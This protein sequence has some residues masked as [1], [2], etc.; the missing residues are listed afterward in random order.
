MSERKKEYQVLA[1][2]YRP[3][4]LEGLIGQ[5]V[6]VQTLTNAIE[7]DRIPHAF[8]M[9]GIRGVGKTSTARIIARSLV[10][11]GKDGKN[12]KPTTKPCGV[13]NQCMAIANDSHVDILEM[14][15][16]SRTGVND[17]REII[18]NVHYAPVMARYKIYII[19]EVHMLS[20]SAFNALLK[21]L[22]EPPEHTKFIFATTEI[23]KIP[24]TVL[25][26]CMRFDLARVPV[27]LLNEHLSA[28]AK[29]EKVK[30]KDDALTLISNSA[31]GSVRDA[32]SLLDQAIGISNKGDAIDVGLVSSMLGVADSAAMYDLF[33]DIVEG[34]PK[35][36]IEQ[37]RAM[38][39][40]GADP[41]TILQDLLEMSHFIT[42]LK[43]IPEMASA[44]HL[45]ETDVKRGKDMAAKLSIPYLSRM[46][47]MLLKGVQEAQYAPNSLVAAEMIL[48]RL[49]YVSDAPTPG[50]LIKKIQSEGVASTASS[51]TQ[52]T[53]SS[54][55]NTVQASADG[56]IRNP[57]NFSEMVELFKVKGEKLKCSYLRNISVIDFDA[58]HHKV[59]FSSA[60]GVPT[61]F[62]GEVGEMLTRWTGER[63]VFVVSNA[64]GQKSLRQQEEEELAS[65]KKISRN[66]PT[67]LAI[68]E[69]FPGAKIIEMTE[70]KKPDMKGEAEIIDLKIGAKE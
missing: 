7:N 39:M 17:I 61:N 47:Q 69:S 31:E 33:S 3:Y 32:L 13:C 5:N 18:E 4:E 22:E 48:V 37:I 53:A 1:R 40:A 9:T 68:L 58:A 38:Y 36:A 16:A 30:I 35:E 21:T 6:L 23:R 42:Q 41:V 57:I 26:R 60:E 44:P 55:D 52:N 50:D 70:V 14:D 54:A 43:V 8:I 12:T 34:K 67:I 27:E 24:V 28:I 10:C 66:D 65:R 11:V 63:W 56:F 20:K 51:P 62:A 59:E 15:A 64:Q 25:S 2:K 19:D 46:W 45:A 49:T 29:K